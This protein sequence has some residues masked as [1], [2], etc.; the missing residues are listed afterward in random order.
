MDFAFGIIGFL[1][2]EGIK[3]RNRLWA[4]L[5][6]PPEN[7]KLWYALTLFCLSVF[8]GVVAMAVAD[9]NIAKA[10]YA[11]F[12]LPTVLK[13]LSAIPR[14]GQGVQADEGLTFDDIELRNP[15]IFRRTFLWMNSY[16]RF[17]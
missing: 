1:G 15:S 16:F 4:N 12:S 8:S 2:F 14:S 7:R 11:G 6:I 13:T 10:L 5:P 9:G 3:I 17:K